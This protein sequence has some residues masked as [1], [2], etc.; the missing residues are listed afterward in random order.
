MSVLCGVPRIAYVGSGGSFVSLLRHRRFLWSRWCLVPSS[1]QV[2]RVKPSGVWAFL[3]VVRYQEP[4][5]PYK[6]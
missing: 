6:S 1:F 2:D 3:D 4:Y 5:Q